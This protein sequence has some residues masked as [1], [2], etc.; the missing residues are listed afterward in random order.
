MTPATSTPLAEALAVYLQFPMDEGEAVVV[1]PD[2]QVC[3]EVGVVTGASCRVADLVGRT[4]SA[5]ALL[6]VARRGRRPRPADLVL[7][8]ELCA[9]LDGSVT[10]LLP[11]QV[12]PAA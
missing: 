8:S 9:A 1:L 7:W 12:L 11:L 6:A 5:T 2:E 4:G 3:L 10:T